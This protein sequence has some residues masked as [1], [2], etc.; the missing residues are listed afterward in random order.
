MIRRIDHKQMG[1]SNLGWLH[2]IFHFSFAEYYNPDNIEF[3]KL[4]VI[5]DDLIAP[6]TGF[7][8]HPHKDMEIVSYVIDGNL[9]H[10]D[11][12]RNEQT[13][14]RGEVQYMSA[15][16]GVYHSE[17]NWGKETAR[18]LQIWIR[19][20]RT[21]Y[22]PNYGDY[23]FPWEDRHNHWLHLVS[24]EKGDAPVKLHQDAN[25]FALELDAGLETEFIVAPERQAYL[26]QIEG[27][28]MINGIQMDPKDGLETRE[29]SLSIHAVETCHFLV[30]EMKKK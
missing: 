3:G 15:G 18:L 20:D 26:V 21:G 2:S 27:T 25:I 16:T 13:L 28:S 11:S 9:T 30:I 5:N 29:E 12:M 4:R 23:R 10:K 19:P 14:K 7:D 24:G 1:K 6:G 22:T 8:T 17:F